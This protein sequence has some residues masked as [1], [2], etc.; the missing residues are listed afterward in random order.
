MNPWNELLPTS[1]WIDGSEYEIRSDYRAVLDICTAL[2]D[3]ELNEQERAY[4]ALDI[5]YP[6]LETMRQEHYQEAIERCLNFISGPGPKNP[7]KTPKLVDWEQDFD[8]VVAPI[9]R[10]LGKEIRALEYLH[11][12]T[13][14]SAYQ[15]IGDCTFAQVVRIRDRLA[16]GKKLDKQDREWYNR[17]RHLV[18][19]QRKYTSAD[20]ALLREWGGA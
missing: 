10:V 1:V 5:F 13:W 18:D 14:L 7:R 9:N 11:Y 3:N 15:E 12:W 6:G 2:N 17:N 4:V 8:L 19:F 20:E 16:R